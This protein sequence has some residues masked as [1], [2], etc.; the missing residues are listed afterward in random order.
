MLEF[1]NDILNNTLIRDAL[2]SCKNRN[3][4]QLASRWKGKLHY[5]VR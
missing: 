5:L 3:E 4:E 1:N 2:K